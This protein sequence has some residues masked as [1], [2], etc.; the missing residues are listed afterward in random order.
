MRDAVAGAASERDR[1]MALEAEVS[2][3][4]RALCKEV[5]RGCGVEVRPGPGAG[6]MLQ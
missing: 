3:L 6:T 1:R 2:K 5:A 4:R